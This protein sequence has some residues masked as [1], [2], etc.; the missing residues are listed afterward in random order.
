MKLKLNHLYRMIGRR[1]YSTTN[2]IMVV[3]KVTAFDFQG[4]TLVNYSNTLSN[5]WYREFA[6]IEHIYTIQDLGHKYNHP[7]HFL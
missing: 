6:N 5:S 2:E 4:V 1:K 3:T 7:E